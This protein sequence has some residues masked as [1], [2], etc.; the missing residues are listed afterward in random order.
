MALN[1]P[2][3]ES[4][5]GSISLKRLKAAIPIL[6]QRIDELQAID[7]DVIQE[8][9]EE[10]LDA[11]EQKIDSTLAEKGVC[12]K[13]T[14]IHGNQAIRYDVQLHF[15]SILASG[16][17]DLTGQEINTREWY[18]IKFSDIKFMDLRL[19]DEEPVTGMKHPLVARATCKDGKVLDIVTCKF[20]TL[21]GLRADGKRVAYVFSELQKLETIDLNYK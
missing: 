11:I 9:N 19:E 1:M 20:C 21:S 2:S 6:K 17:A 10:R 15:G 3:G 7:V 18:N 13:L 5:T 12:M 16:R 4:R 14:D 8:H